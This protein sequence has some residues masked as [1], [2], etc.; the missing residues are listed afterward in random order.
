MATKGAPQSR[1]H[2]TAVHRGPCDRVR[3]VLSTVCARQRPPAIVVH[4][5]NNVVYMYATATTIIR[6]S[7]D[8]AKKF[9]QVER[10]KTDEAFNIMHIV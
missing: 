9:V 2:R 3:W 7:A 6:F 10:K 1:A 4:V 8:H 5:K